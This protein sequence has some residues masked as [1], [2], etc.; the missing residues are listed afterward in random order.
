MSR[1]DMAVDRLEPALEHLENTAAPLTVPLEGGIPPA[2]V[3]RNWIAS[4]SN[5]SPGSRCW[6]TKWPL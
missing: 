5:C 6:R 3:W 2:P 4:G 1:L